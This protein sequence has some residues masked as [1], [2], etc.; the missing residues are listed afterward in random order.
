MVTTTVLTAPNGL[1]Q[2]QV[3]WSALQNAALMPHDIDYVEAHGT[4]TKL[5]D[6]IEMEALGNVYGKSRAPENP[7]KVGCG[8]SKYWSFRSS[9]GYCWIDQAR[10]I[11]APSNHTCTMFF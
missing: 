8:Q 6:P 7:F 4:G 1:A 9:S 10:A 5:G 11:T 2:E 3:I